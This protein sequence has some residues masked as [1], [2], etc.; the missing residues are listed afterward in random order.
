MKYLS[1]IA[2]LM[3]VSALAQAADTAAP[4]ATG[5]QGSPLASMLP[6]VLIFFVFYFLLIRPQQKRQKELVSMQSALKKGDEI[7]TSGGIVAKFVREGDAGIVIVEI[8]PGVEVKL[9]KATI[10]S[11]ANKTPAATTI[12]ANQLKKKSKDNA[13]IKNDN[14]VPDK[15]QVA[16]DN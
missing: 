13:L 7:V 4:A 11:V 9:L 14:V 2:A 6:L 3:P 12:P 16:N 5:I 8:A 15:D 10:A 1:F